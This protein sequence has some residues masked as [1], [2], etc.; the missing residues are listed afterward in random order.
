MIETLIAILVY[1]VAVVVAY[2]LMGKYLDNTLV[3][4]VE[5][6]EFEDENETYV[7]K[8]R[9]ITGFKKRLL[10]PENRVQYEVKKEERPK[11]EVSEQP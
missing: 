8:K 4:G 3:E 6:A 11:T 5:V 10:R 1:C 2:S 7:V 9:E